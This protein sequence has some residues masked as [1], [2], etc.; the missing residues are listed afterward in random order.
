MLGLLDEA[1]KRCEIEWFCS[2]LDYRSYEMLKVFSPK[3]LKI[4]STISNHV[5]FH[6]QIANDYRSAIVVSTG[7]TE[8]SYVDYV[9]ETFA[10]N[11]LI[12]LLHCVS[13]YPTPRSACNVAVVRTY[14]EL[15]VE[16]N[17]KSLGTK[18]IPGYSSHDLG[19]QACML[20]VAAGA[21]MLEKHVKLGNADW[22]H[23]DKVAVDLES[24]EFLRFVRDVRVAE[25]ISGSATKRVLDC[26]HHK[27]TRV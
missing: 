2:A 1:C 17:S 25:E 26:E 13:A 3:L 21:R 15:S 19:S 7:F 9:L 4:P 27:Y 20:A 5:D 8:K 14:S 23:F 24:D 6:R 10:E 22:I 12:Y 11:N 16:Q 18:I